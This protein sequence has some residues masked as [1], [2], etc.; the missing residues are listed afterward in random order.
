[1]IAQTGKDGCNRVIRSS[2][3]SERIGAEKGES[4]PVEARNGFYANLKPSLDH[5]ISS[6]RHPA[7]SKPGKHN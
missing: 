5:L 3:F 1:M 4:Q 7:F 2:N 6:N